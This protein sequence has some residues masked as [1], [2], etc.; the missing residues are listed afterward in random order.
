MMNLPAYGEKRARPETC[1]WVGQVTELVGL[2]VESNGPSAGV[3]DFCEINT[4]G[5][6][7]IRTQVIGFRDGRVLSMPLEET[8]GWHLGDPVTARQEDPALVVGAPSLESVIVGFV[9]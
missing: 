6:R 5:G 8:D 9:R 3:G 4:Q 2:L 7:V 1:R